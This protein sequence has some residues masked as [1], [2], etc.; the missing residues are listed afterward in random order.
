MVIQL[1]DFFP[2]DAAK[3]AHIIR[4]LC[5]AIMQPDTRNNPVTFHHLCWRVDVLS[6]AFRMPLPE[7][8]VDP[9]PYG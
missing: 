6:E 7:W 3:A 5:R 1:A 2:C 8:Y 4:I 9:Y